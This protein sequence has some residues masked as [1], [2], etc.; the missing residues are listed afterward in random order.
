MIQV[1][2]GQFAKVF[3]TFEFKNGGL[4]AIKLIKLRPNLDSC[5]IAAFKHAVSRIIKI[6]HPNLV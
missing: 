6:G 2:Q 3:K 4:V 1:G 5:E